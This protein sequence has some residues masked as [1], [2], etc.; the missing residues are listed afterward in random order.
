VGEAEETVP[1]WAAG[2]PVA[3]MLKTAQRASVLEKTSDLIYVLQAGIPGF[4]PNID[5]R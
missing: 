4:N 5:L 2:I 1:P 3:E